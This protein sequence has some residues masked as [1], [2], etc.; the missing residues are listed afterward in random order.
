ML[1]A[2]LAGCLLRRWRWIPAL[3]LAPAVSA[4]L[5]YV[6]RYRADDAALGYPVLSFPADWREYLLMSATAWC[7]FVVVATCCYG[8]KRAW[9]W[10]S[11]EAT[12]KRRAL[13]EGSPPP[14]Q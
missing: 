3:A 5:F 11:P 4:P 14:A 12:E 9:V 2:V 6:L 1:L 13:T 8:L 10:V 7:V